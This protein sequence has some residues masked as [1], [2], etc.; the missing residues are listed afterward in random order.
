VASL[1]ATRPMASGQ[2]LQLMVDLNLLHFFDAA[3]GR[4][5]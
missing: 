1:E 2:V 4:A 3:S 5:I